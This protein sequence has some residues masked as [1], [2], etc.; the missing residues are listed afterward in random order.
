MKLELVKKEAR[1]SRYQVR[2]TLFRLRDNRVE[3]KILAETIWTAISSQLKPGENLKG[4]TFDWDVDPKNPLVVL[5]RSEWDSI[6]KEKY[7]REYDMQSQ[8]EEEITLF[9]GQK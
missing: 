6:K 5:R 3:D 1:L 9:T 8:V 7:P 2:N 4:F